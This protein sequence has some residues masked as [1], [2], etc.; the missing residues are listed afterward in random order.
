M[1]GSERLAEA[2]LRSAAAHPG[3]EA[4]FRSEAERALLEEALLHGVT[5]EL[6]LEVTLVTGKADAVFNRL[7]VEWEPPGAMAASPGHRGNRHAVDQVR[8]YVN[9][10]AAKERRALERL[11]G[12]ACD[13]R[14][15]VFSRYR[16]GR[17]IVDDPVPVDEA[18]AGQLLRSLIA[19]QTGRA[20]TAENL[21]RD[22]SGDALLT[23]QLTGA[24]LQQLDAQLGQH[25]DGLPAKLFGQ[26]ERLFAVATGVTGEGKPL[27]AKSKRMLERIAGAGAG[28]DP[29][30]TLFCLQTTSRS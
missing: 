18:S 19:A 1:K 21:L 12:V 9:G 4:G 23:R 27:D 20:L 7:V 14:W 11:S 6:Q 3:D 5:L 22:F 15:M 30:R 25:P 8:K 13:G 10:L 28:A 17:W 29:S 2:L 24:L 26:W 16:A